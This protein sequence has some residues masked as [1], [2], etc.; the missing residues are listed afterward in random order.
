MNAKATALR[1]SSHLSV[2]VFLLV[3]FT[4]VYMWIRHWWIGPTA[5]TMAQGMTW[6]VLL[7]VTLVP[8]LLISKLQTRGA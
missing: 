2:G 4:S 5:W 6:T 3:G 1:W 8:V 7:A